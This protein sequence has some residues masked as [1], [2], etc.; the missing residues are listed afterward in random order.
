MF[1]RPPALAQHLASEIEATIGTRGLEPGERITTMEELRAQTG[2]GRATISETARL[3]AERGTVDVRPGRGG[4]LFVAENTPMVRLRRTLLAVPEGAASVSD[5]IAV[6]DALEELIALEASRHR[7]E[8]DIRELE[9]CMASMRQAAHDLE[10]FLQANW[11]L[12]ERIAAI[13]PNH[14][15][16][17]VYV[18]TI[19][20]IAE[21][22]VRADQEASSVPD[23]LTHRLAVHADLVHAIV[24]GDEDLTRAAIA[25][26]QEIAVGHAAE[27]TDPSSR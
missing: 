9:A 4:G 12:H 21:L 14:L 20:C 6:R 17:A 7:T 2:Y 3:L 11:T 16:R 25:A 1:S 15:A 10:L 26:H 13:T 24:R 27:Q 5:A 19:K 22:A 8:S 23:Y 18:S